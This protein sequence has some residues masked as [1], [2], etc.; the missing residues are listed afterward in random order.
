MIIWL[1]R[2]AR[3]AAPY[4]V[5]RVMDQK[6]GVGFVQKWEVASWQNSGSGM[7][8]SW[9]TTYAGSSRVKCALAVR[10]ARAGT[11]TVRVT[12]RG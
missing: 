7:G 11:G 8:W 5:K 1:R 3:V 12:F 2:L 9:V 6:R 10:R 4:L